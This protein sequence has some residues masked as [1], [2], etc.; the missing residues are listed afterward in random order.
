M[1]IWNLESKKEYLTVTCS[2]TLYSRIEIGYNLTP[3]VDLKWYR[4][5]IASYS[6][7]IV[8]RAIATTTIPH[9]QE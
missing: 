4:V 2:G 6:Y 1:G 9:Y 7:R 3:S 5:S 8:F